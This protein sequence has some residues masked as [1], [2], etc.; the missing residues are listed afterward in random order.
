MSS[1]S[2]TCISCRVAFASADLQ[3]AHYKSD[4]HRYNLKR[5]VAELP[6]VTATE[7][8]QRVLAQQSKTA[9]EQRDTSTNCDICGKHFRTENAYANHLQSKKHKEVEAKS[10]A[11]V[12]VDN[13]DEVAAKNAKNKR[14]HASVD[15]YEGQKM[16][17]EG[18]GKAKEKKTDNVAASSSS[19][20][21]SSNPKKKEAPPKFSKYTGECT[22]HPVRPSVT[23]NIF[24]ELLAYTNIL[25]L[26]VLR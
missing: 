26:C 7:F 20:S 2:F 19:S 16:M 13:R 3:R 5:K 14:D 11:A 25:T 1:A 9:E 23:V 22:S 21:S 10:K 8:K 15:A 24:I 18:A 6:P 12:P 4:W 17:R